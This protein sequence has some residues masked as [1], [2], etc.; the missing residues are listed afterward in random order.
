MKPKKTLVF[1]GGIVLLFAAISLYFIFAS[2]PLVTGK[3]AEVGNLTIDFI[4]T[5]NNYQVTSVDIDNPENIA[6]IFSALNQGRARVNHRPDHTQSIQ[7]DSDAII[8]ITYLD[9]H[10]DEVN[11]TKS[12]AYRFLDTKGGSGD[13]GFVST[14]N[15]RIYG[16]LLSCFPASPEDLAQYPSRAIYS[17]GII[18]S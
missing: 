1:A 10:T 5:L 8:R 7:L 17:P 18:Y 11:V 3:P 2:E 13:P 14:G 4:D 9:G 16:V 12:L 15:D 6:T